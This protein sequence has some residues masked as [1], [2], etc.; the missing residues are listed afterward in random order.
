MNVLI[1][2]DPKQAK[3]IYRQ[4]VDELINAIAEGYLKPGEKL[5]S[6][7]DLGKT[8]GISRFTVMRSF[9]DLVSAGYIKIATGSGAFI[10]PDLADGHAQ[11]NAKDEQQILPPTTLSQRRRA[12]Q[13]K[14]A[15]CRASPLRW[16]KQA[17]SSQT[18]L[19]LILSLITELR[20]LTCFP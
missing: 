12:Q 16:P 3:P 14:S 19:T 7:R 4:I 18:P 8:L 11:T 13:L 2:I 15:A 20:P 5:P 1:N 10:N 17:S 6:T 9:E